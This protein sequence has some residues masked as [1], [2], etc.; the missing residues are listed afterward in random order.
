MDVLEAPARRPQAVASRRPDGG[1]IDLGERVEST[2]NSLNRAH[3]SPR[4]DALVVRD[5][6]ERLR[7]RSRAEDDSD[8]RIVGQ[9][10]ELAC[11]HEDLWRLSGGRERERQDG[12]C[13]SAEHAES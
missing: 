3:V 6:V 2:P 7:Q 1:E 12:E 13:D 4:D 8:L 11:P 5:D 9:V 10:T